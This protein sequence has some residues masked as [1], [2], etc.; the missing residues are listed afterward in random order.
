MSDW[1]SALIARTLK[2]GGT[3]MP[4]RG[5]WNFA[6]GATAAD[7]PST[8]ATDIYVSGG[9]GGGGVAPGDTVVGAVAGDAAADV[10]DVWTV[11]SAGNCN[12]SRPAARILNIGDSL[13]TRGDSYATADIGAMIAAYAAIVGPKNIRIV[14]TLTMASGTYDCAGEPL[15]G[16]GIISVLAASGGSFVNCPGAQ[17][18]MI[19]STS[20]SAVIACATLGGS[21]IFFADGCVFL[22]TTAGI[23]AA[24]H[25]LNVLATNKTQIVNGGYEAINF[26]AHGGS[27]LCST[28]ASFAANTVR[29]SGDPSITATIADA[30]SAI[31]S[32]A[33]GGSNFI[34]TGYVGDQAEDVAC[35][36]TLGAGALQAMPGSGKVIAWPA[37]NLPGSTTLHEWRGGESFVS[38]QIAADQIAGV[39]NA[40]LMAATIAQWKAQQNALGLANKCTV[41]TTLAGTP[42]GAKADFSAVPIVLDGTVGILVEAFVRIAGGTS[43]TAGLVLV[44][45]SP[46]TYGPQQM[47]CNFTNTTLRYIINPYGGDAYDKQIDPLISQHRCRWVHVAWAWSTVSPTGISVFLDGMWLDGSGMALNTMTMK[48]LHIGGTNNG[49]YQTPVEFMWAAITNITGITPANIQLIVSQHYNACK[50]F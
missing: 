2:V 31:G 28:G 36:R 30:A 27:I 11:T 34:I 26:Q 39:G 35:P 38:S 49:D 50:G 7:N 42:A 47:V 25:T 8:D 19:N 32:Q 16:D 9:G 18:I 48:V 12:W 46:N 5:T 23:I 20:A 13:T 6:T 37:Q 29:S 22:S 3:T 17:R 21:E 44:L 10:G 33:N 43:T 14:G 24:T 1:I 4:A 40:P 15:L 41:Q 45:T